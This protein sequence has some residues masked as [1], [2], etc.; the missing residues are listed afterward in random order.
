[1]EYLFSFQLFISLPMYYPLYP[2]FYKT[3]SSLYKLTIVTQVRVG[4]E[5]TDSQRGA[6]DMSWLQSS[7]I[8]QAQVE[9]LSY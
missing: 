2:F 9:C 7:H 3:R 5:I 6:L 1:M 4:Y 8:E